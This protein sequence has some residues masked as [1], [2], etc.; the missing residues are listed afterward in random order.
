VKRGF[1]GGS[2]DLTTGSRCPF[3]ANDRPKANV[4]HERSGQELESGTRESRV[5]GF[6][7]M[8][9][10]EEADKAISG[11]IGWNLKGRPLTVNE[12]RLRT[13]GFGS[14]RH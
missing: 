1:T 4:F 13:G 10:K 11:L 9:N 3:S 12:A 8:P 14:G 7:E 6:V 2:G 5:F